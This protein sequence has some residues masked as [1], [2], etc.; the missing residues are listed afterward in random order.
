MDDL[1]DGTSGNGKPEN[2]D[3]AAASARVFY[4][5]LRRI[6]IEIVSGRYGPGDR[7]MTEVESAE[8]LGISRASYREAIRTLTAKG[9]L[10]SRPKVGTVVTPRSNWQLMD[11]DILDW[12]LQ[13]GPTADYINA[14]FELRMCIEPLVASLAAQR[15]TSQ[16][17]ATMKYSLRSLSQTSLISEAGKAAMRRFYS[18]ILEATG[19]EMFTSLAPGIGTVATWVTAVKYHCGTLPETAIAEHM[20]LVT[21]IETEKSETA[22]AAASALLL[23]AHEQINRVL[24]P[25]AVA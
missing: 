22:R 4:P 19:N 17:L 20:R 5:V 10:T 6:G 12:S 24:F 3:D 14:V 21:A 7:L 25:P 8:N 9:L 2:D 1:E 16:H 23:T 18:A 11:P 15:R 13:S